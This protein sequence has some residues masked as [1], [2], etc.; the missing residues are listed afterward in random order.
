MQGILFDLDGVLYLGDEPIAGAAAVVR[1]VQRQ[2]IPHLYLTNTTSRPRSALVEKLA[3]FDIR[4]AADQLLTPA[5]AAVEWLRREA[6]GPL[7]LFVPEATAVEFADRPQLAGHADQGAAAVVVG[8]LGAGWDFNRLNRAFR[9]LMQTP[10]P[11]LVALG[12]TRFWRADDGLRLDT[13]PFVQALAYASGQR[14]VVMGKPS[15]AFFGAAAELLGLDAGELVMIGDD[16]R[17][18]VEGARNAGIPALLV[19][20]GKFRA[21]DLELGIKPQAV[22]DSVADLPAWWHARKR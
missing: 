12:M 16:I 13:G 9:L 22:L 18:D 3:G 2:G 21:G 14:P 8:D 10:Q 20:T 4:V 19:R 7:A 17:G 15:A 1:W 11:A 5:V 6:D